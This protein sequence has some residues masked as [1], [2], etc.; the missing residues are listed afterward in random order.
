[1]PKVFVTLAIG[2]AA[3]AFSGAVAHA[4]I[5][6]TITETGTIGGGV[7]Q[8][9]FGVRGSSLAGQTF[10]VTQ[11]FDATLSTDNSGGPVYDYLS[12]AAGGAI[13]TVG[14][15]TYT[16]LSNG[17]SNNEY[18]ISS[19][20]GGYFYDEIYGRTYSSAN[21]ASYTGYV[22]S[23][24]TNFLAGDALSQTLVYTLPNSVGSYAGFSGP[25]SSYFTGS[26]NTI[27]VNAAPATPAV[28]EPGSAAL[29]SVGLIGLGRLR[30]RWVFFQKLRRQCP[31]PGS[32]VAVEHRH[33]V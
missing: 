26:L 29:F 32:G 8:G 30:R 20:A 5:I 17:N 33:A 7:S 12:P 11:T 28:P 25:D 23:L 24:A 13:V 10:S 1:M 2:L 19:R 9:I 31:P 18:L 27:S 15:N 16:I 21:N 6:Y 22:Y 3:V 4:D 14:N